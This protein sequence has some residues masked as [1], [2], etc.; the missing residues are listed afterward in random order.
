MS[1]YSEM[2]QLADEMIDEYGQSVILTK[3]S[4]TP[5]DATKPWRGST[6]ADSSTQAMAVLLD[7]SER[8]QDGEI[9]RRGDQKAYVAAVG[10]PDLKEYDTLTQAGG[11]QFRI[12]NVITLNPGGTALLFELHL[13]K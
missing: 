7:Y 3:N 1:F 11:S 4:T 10:V 6:N 8:E 12:Q 5:S 13:R 9:I 2:A